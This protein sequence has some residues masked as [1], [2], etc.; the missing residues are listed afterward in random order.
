MMGGKDGELSEAV[1]L[2][3]VAGRLKYD[4]RGEETIKVN[5]QSQHYILASRRIYPPCFGQVELCAF[6][7]C[8]W[9]QLVKMM[10]R[11]NVCQGH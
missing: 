4:R 9:H 2:A 10:V 6:S 8:H 11:V 5:V 3:L 7:A 1:V